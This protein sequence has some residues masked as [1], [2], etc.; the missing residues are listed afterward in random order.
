MDR[1]RVRIDFIFDPPLQ[2]GIHLIGMPSGRPG[3]LPAAL[4]YALA[5]GLDTTVLN[6]TGRSGASRPVSALCPPVTSMENMS[7]IV[8]EVG[9]GRNLEK[10]VASV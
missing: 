6:L 4:R 3:R 7:G 9:I 1:P 5:T 8:Y 10:G 2:L